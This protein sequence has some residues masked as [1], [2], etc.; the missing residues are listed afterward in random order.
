MKRRAHAPRKDAQSNVVKPVAGR[1]P[2]EQK[3]AYS[4]DLADPSSSR[5]FF[6]GPRWGRVPYLQG[7]RRG[8]ILAVAPYAFH[9][10]PHLRIAYCFTDGAYP[11]ERAFEAALTAE[12]AYPGLA[13][14][15]EVRLRF[16]MN[17]LERV[18]RA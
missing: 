14:G 3:G 13:P 10:M 17:I 15:D 9:G 16:L 4:S 7:E 1:R 18:E 12:Q 6:V 5:R 8:R 2:V 11:E